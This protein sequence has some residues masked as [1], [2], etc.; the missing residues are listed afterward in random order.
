MSR[1]AVQ[2]KYSSDLTLRYFNPITS[3]ER[4]VNQQWFIQDRARSWNVWGAGV[5]AGGPRNAAFCAGSESS[6]YRVGLKFGVPFPGWT[7]SLGRRLCLS[8]CGCGASWKSLL[9]EAAKSYFKRIA[10]WAYWKQRLDWTS[11]AKALV[12]FSA[13]LGAAGER[14]GSFEAEHWNA[15]EVAGEPCPT[16]YSWCCPQH[17]EYIFALES[18][19]EMNVMQDHTRPFWWSATAGKGFSGSRGTCILHRSFWETLSRQ[20]QIRRR[21][22]QIRLIVRNTG[23]YWKCSNNTDFLEETLWTSCTM[24]E[25]GTYSLMAELDQ[26]QILLLKDQIGEKRGEALEREGS[27]PSSKHTNCPFVSGLFAPNTISQRLRSKLRSERK[28]RWN[29][30]WRINCLKY[31]W[32]EKSQSGAGDVCSTRK[33]TLNCSQGL[34]HEETHCGAI[35]AGSERRERPEARRVSSS[36]EVG[37]RNFH[38]TGGCQRDSPQIAMWIG[39]VT[40]HQIGQE[41]RPRAGGAAENPTGRQCMNGKIETGYKRLGVKLGYPYIGM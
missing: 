16:V 41:Y 8:V 31:V 20:T 1:P 24:C 4:K 22:G 7:S 33:P 13:L 3:L 32:Q 14:P 30:R 26:A 19:T 40:S 29:R 23:W 5:S 9:F 2:K 34:Q 17:C 37:L 12:L 18:S 15:A 38:L 25:L 6:D 35:V 11:I 10:C 21:A 28:R 39:N 36:Q 27:M